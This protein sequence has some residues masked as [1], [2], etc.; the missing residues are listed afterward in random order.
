MLGTLN[1]LSLRMLHRHPNHMILQA[2]SLSE[3][4]QQML[5]GYLFFTFSVKLPLVSFRI[6]ISLRGALGR[7]IV[8]SLVKAPDTINRFLEYWVSVTVIT[9]SIALSVVSVIN[10]ASPY[11]IKSLTNFVVAIEVSL[12]KTVGVGAF[13]SPVNV[14]EFSS[15][16]SLPTSKCLS[17]Y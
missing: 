8:I 17:L 7:T 10:A 6:H 14:G 5:I 11:T 9:P 12:L 16:L 15:A 2:H 3:E 4:L 1:L 13:G